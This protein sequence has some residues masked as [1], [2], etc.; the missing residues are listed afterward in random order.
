MEMINFFDLKEEDLKVLNP[1]DFQ[2]SLNRLNNLTLEDVKNDLK[3]F[4]KK[5]FDFRTYEEEVS[6]SLKSI[7]FLTSFKDENGESIYYLLKDL[8][9]FLIPENLDANKNKDIRDNKE[10]KRIQLDIKNGERGKRT[11]LIIINVDPE[12]LSSN[13][14]NN[15]IKV[16]K[17]ETA[18]TVL[19]QYKNTKEK[20]EKNEWN[21]KDNKENKYYFRFTIKIDT[22]QLNKIYYSK[23]EGKYLLDLQSPPLFRTNFF[24]SKKDEDK[25]KE[26]DK[27]KDKDKPMDENCVFPFRNFENEI[28]NLEYRHFIIMLEK[29]TN[30]TPCDEYDNYENF[31]TNAE[32]TSSL[33]NLFIDINGQVDEK[34][35]FI[36]QCPIYKPKISQKA[37]S[38]YFNYNKNKE[39][40]KKLVQLKFLKEQDEEEEEIE[41]NEENDNKTTEESNED[42]NQV[43]KLFYQ[44]LAL[45]SECILS[46]YNAS[47]FL[48]KLFSSNYDYRNTIF[49]KCKYEQF[50]KFFN[51]TLNKILDR[52]QN[53]GEEKSLKEF[54]EEMKNTFNSLYTQ[55][56]T[57]GFEEIW[58]PSK[59]KILKRIQRCII[60]PTY[61]LFFPYVLDQGNRVLRE[62]IKSTSDTMLCTFKMDN[63]KEDRW[64]NDILVE[65][66]KFILSKGFKIGDKE[67]SFFNY[68][69]SQF[70]NMSCWLSTN[71]EET[72]KKLG[73][74]SKI[75]PVSKYAAR[76]S[77]TLTTTIRT[78]KIPKDKIKEIKDKKI[79]VKKGDK[80]VEYNFSDGVG[81][82]SYTLAKQINDEFLKLNYVPSC[83]Q[84][85]F[86][87]CKGVWTTMWDDNSGNIYYR[88]SQ[89]KFEV[90]HDDN[91]KN[92]YYF[93][94]CDYSRYI[95]SYLN[96]QVILLLKAL[97]IQDDKFLNKL[98]DYR[99]KL[100]N[101]KFVLSLIHYP[102]WYRIF[103]KMF[104]SGI[105]RTNDRLLKTLI[106]SNLDILYRDIKNKAR[107]Y[108]DESA[109]VK[110]IMDEFGILK[111]G[112][113]Y[114]HIKR[115]NLDLILDKKCAVAKCPCLHPGDIRVLTFKKYNKNNPSTKK[116]EIFNRYENVIIF[117]QKGDRPH[118]NE[119]S[120][121]DLDGDDYFVFY[122]SDLIPEK[123]VDPMD[124]DADSKPN[125]Q[126]E[127]YTIKDVIEYFAVYTNYNTL[128]L[129]GDAHVAFSDKEKGGANSSKSKKL[130]KKFSEA[131]DAPKTGVKIDLDSEEKPKEYPHYMEK[132][133][134]NSYHSNN[135]LGQLYDESNEM[136]LQR[137]KRNYINN[138][139]YDEDL[140]LKGWET[141]AFL[142]LI[143]Y[144][145]YF[146][147]FLNMLKKNEIDNETILLT[148]NNIDNENSIF[149][150][151]K[152]NYDIR[153]KI[154]IEMH[155]LFIN[156]QNS[157]NNAINEF[158]IKD[159][160][161]GKMN[162][163]DLINISL[164]FKRNLH[165]FASSCYVISYNLLEDVLNKKIN[166]NP[167]LDTYYK[168]YISLINNNLSSDDTF[169]E[170]TEISEYESSLLGTDYYES[171]EYNNK[172]TYE[173][174][175]NKKNLINDTIA[176][177]KKDM[178]YYIKELKSMD[179]PKQPNEENQYRI[180]SFPWCI[181]GN[182]LSNIKYT[183]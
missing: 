143:Y 106:E 72:I 163:K 35:K 58:R 118:P 102:E 3:Y 161:K 71:P 12:K 69:Q 136:I 179:I 99:K 178:D 110:G 105:N 30:D 7:K 152:N 26:K 177:K 167:V 1:Y 48:E 84:G 6:Y 21:N 139:F 14:L 36:K 129:I 96:R 174:I 27:D 75:K 158:F 32:L 153:E 20:I 63:L 54:E 114:L 80:E 9:E 62:Y 41:S 108:V 98:R 168:E 92:G 94:L 13:I 157:F 47:K 2:E 112:E 42:E 142:A 135:I 52:Y 4:Q 15:F 171:F 45:V 37:L 43:T 65:Y 103:N 93:E 57:D 176:K 70:R 67:F 95:Q 86:M 91:D 137:V 155:H 19:E 120:G 38:F 90:L 87:G 119:C 170:I 146:N 156:N 31:D 74:F 123:T 82:I 49:D 162:E 55:N 34:K 130:A 61:I 148:G 23:E 126:K 145:D 100:E 160:E 22:K 117:P 127:P 51:L 159:I 64:N 140:K 131:V 56:E 39:V 104:T 24:N 121:S 147:E 97:G 165:L 83:F 18:M 59:N 11:I 81:K 89:K 40:K 151:K 5:D 172:Y 101:Q 25:D 150:K 122:D 113:A 50:P 53:S 109:Y 77:Q 17:F 180:L 16:S 124:Y 78:I 88:G 76:I 183:I 173:Q 182:V 154:S 115:D 181:A 134:N 144:R 73:D 169:E 44:I 66:I 166:Q 128:G 141:F 107:I 111:Y 33:G 125:E 8:D 79:K 29:D 116:Y 60:T 138:S 28:D 46:Y 149:Q 10:F 175:E 133:K 68:S 85:R 164:I 132:G